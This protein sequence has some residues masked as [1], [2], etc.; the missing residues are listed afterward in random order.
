M[1]KKRF[2]SCVLHIGTEKTGS[3][4]IQHYLIENRH[5]LSRHGVL[6]PVAASATH[7]SQWTQWIIARRRILRALPVFA[8]AFFAL[9]ASLVLFT[10]RGWREAPMENDTVDTSRLGWLSI[11]TVALIYIQ[12]IFGAVLRHTGVRLDAHLFLAFFV[13]I[14][15]F[16][17]TRKVWSDFRG[18]RA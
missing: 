7:T 1:S 5:R 15:V 10:S 6:F 2:K 11:I 9:T 4:A 18:R 14:N 12:I 3:T 16:F 13:T 17:L 8:Q